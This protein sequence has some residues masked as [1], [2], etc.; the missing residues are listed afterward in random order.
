MT[1][2]CHF[3]NCLELLGTLI[4][5]HLL[6]QYALEGYGRQA[7]EFQSPF[8]FKLHVKI[9]VTPISKPL[10]HASRWQAIQKNDMFS[11]VLH[12]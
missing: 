9:F 3:Q 8:F 10:H 12:Y 4:S 11:K 2:K 6:F 7:L 5:W 1:S